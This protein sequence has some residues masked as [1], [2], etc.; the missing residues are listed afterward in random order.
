M[1]S[2][3]VPRQKASTLP[4]G[5][6]II[7][8]GFSGAMVL[9]NLVRHAAAPLRIAWFEPHEFA[10]GAAYRTN[11]IE[12]LLNVRAERMGAFVGEAGHFLRWLGAPAGQAALAQFWPGQAVTGETYMPRRIY[13]A[14]LQDILA[15]TLERAPA[16][17][18]DITRRKAMV[19]DLIP[20]PGGGAITVS[21]ETGNGAQQIEVQAVVLATGN[22][23]PRKTS[24]QRAETEDYVHDVWRAGSQFPAETVSRLGP[25]DKVV[26]IGTGLTMID[27]VQTLKAQGFTGHITAI[28]RHGLI[29]RPQHHGIAYPSWAWVQ[30]PH[31]APQTVLGLLVRL[32]Q[33]MRD[34]IAQGFGWQ[35]VIESIRPVTRDLWE[36]LPEEERKK[37][38]KRLATFWSIHRHRM[39]P[40]VHS[41]I[42]RFVT[43]NHLRLVAGKIASVSGQ[44]GKLTVTWRNGKQIETLQARLVLNCT[45]PNHDA[46]IGDSTLLQRL[47]ARGL[48][49]THPA[50]GIRVTS[51]SLARGAQQAKIFPMGALLVGE[52]LES[53]AVPEIR[54]QA[55]RI[56]AILL[57]ESQHFSQ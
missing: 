1:E 43:E 11:H 17:N 53:T 56:A 55:G 31:E 36:R 38:S 21:Y 12:H 35:S 49:E 6:A 8:G 48:I 15:Q 57:R 23:P 24:F 29:P 45:G 16:S 27:M 30:A 10:E 22:L 26:L 19:T 18:V 28:S 9:A 41:Q 13:A 37:F 14:Y 32:K 4:Y 33:E 54:D 39:S 40:F 52:F 2:I 50:G 51:D 25:Q 5:I 47:L 46:S 7:G 20:H 42:L 44:D 3:L 34:A